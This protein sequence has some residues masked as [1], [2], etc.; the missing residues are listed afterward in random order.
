MRYTGQALAVVVGA[1]LAG[2]CGGGAAGPAGSPADGSP[3]WMHRAITPQMMR[4]NYDA[5]AYV[6]GVAPYGPGG[7]GNGAVATRVGVPPALQVGMPGA[8]IGTVVGVEGGATMPTP[9]RA[10]LEAAVVVNLS[11]ERCH[12]DVAQEWR[13]SLHHAANT[14]PAYRRAFAIEPLPF[15]RSCHAPEAVPTEVESSLVGGLGVGCVTCHVTGDGAGEL[16]RNAAFGVAVLAAPWRGAG[17]PP[18][19]PHGVVREARFGGA[20]ACAGCHEFAFPTARGGGVESL[21]QSTITE[22]RAS[23]AAGQ[24]CASCHMPAGKT[25]RRS[26]GFV[27]SRDEAFVRSAVTVTARRMSATR[28][29]VTLTPAN[30]GHAFP[31]GDLFRRLSVSAEAL[32]PDEM[33]MGEQERF[34]T[35]HFVLRPGQIGRRLVADDRV[36]G[37]AVVVEL[38]VG[39][40]GVGRTIGWQVAYQRVA[41][42]NGVDERTAT[43][44]GEVRVA[45]GRLPP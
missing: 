37:E 27:G 28:V 32:G 1:F 8:G 26:H 21:M 14:E 13:G 24:S 22:H 20:E 6:H 34:L 30:S 5:W 15:C 3:A 42:P 18:D 9:A 36:H 12:A 43:I 39:P 33:V 10:R 23:A 4:S 16:A 7:V 29:A 40:G 2:A 25:G 38:E 17:K 19:A 31:T 35:R 44:E 41:H 45:S 11:C